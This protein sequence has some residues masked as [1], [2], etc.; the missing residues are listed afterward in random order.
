[1]Y[2]VEKST[3]ENEVWEIKQL[4]ESLVHVD[5]SFR[6]GE[7]IADV[8]PRGASLVDAWENHG[9]N[10]DNYHHIED[11]SFLPNCILFG[12]W[13]VSGV[14]RSQEMPERVNDYYQVDVEA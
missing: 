7:S 1:M 6:H 8:E 12:L 14:Y 13:H 3:P 11:S 4:E 10:D 5:L 9:S 2:Y